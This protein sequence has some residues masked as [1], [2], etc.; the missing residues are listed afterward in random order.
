MNKLGFFKTF[1][2]DIRV[3]ALVPTPRHV[4]DRILAHVPKNTKT[5]AEYGPGDGVITKPLLQCLPEDAKVIA[6][7]RN[8]DFVHEL[9]TIH[10]PRLHVK[11]GD[12]LL[13][14]EYLQEA[15]MHTLDMAISG[16]PFS[17]FKS[18]QRHH[19]I[20]QTYEALSPNGVFVVYQF[21][22]L[23]FFYLKRLFA[24][25]KLRYVWPYFFIM[26]AVKT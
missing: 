7:E 11:Q 17:F 15:R 12:A 23:M 13:A 6:I 19:I 22:P 16:I 2:S 5:V 24:H 1:M 21:S 3:A 4:I 20:T 8:Q 9:A 10:D 25:V 18:T 26:V 14:T